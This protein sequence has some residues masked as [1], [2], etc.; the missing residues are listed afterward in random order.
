MAAALQNGI[1]IKGQAEDEDF[2]LYAA[3]NPQFAEFLRRRCGFRGDPEGSEVWVKKS[4][5]ATPENIEHMEESIIWYN[6]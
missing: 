5:F 4:E 3:T 1:Q 2:Y 6:K